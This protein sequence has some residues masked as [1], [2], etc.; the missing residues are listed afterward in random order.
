MLLTAMAVA[1]VAQRKDVA[2]TALEVA[3]LRTA[4]EQAADDCQRKER[5]I[6]PLKRTIT[7][8]KTDLD[9]LSPMLDRLVDSLNQAALSTVELSPHKDTVSR[10]FVPT[11]TFGD[12]FRERTK[13]YVPANLTCE[14]QVRFFDNDGDPRFFEDFEKPR[15]HS[16]PLAP[17]E[18]LIEVR[19]DWSRVPNAFT[20]TNHTS[21]V[22][23]RSRSK[24][25]RPRGWSPGTGQG[26]YGLS[27]F[28]AQRGMT[29]F[30]GG[31]GFKY[32]T[33]IVVQMVESK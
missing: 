13:L 20:L 4:I 25:T 7:R 22:S 32:G 31:L 6:E 2:A 12:V 24:Y 3:T 17:G 18:N 19:F 5:E 15:L 23:I 28:S 11:L 33:R 14:L 16:I 1:I 29:V 8:Q 10:K 27:V 21:A 30:A 9:R 26:M